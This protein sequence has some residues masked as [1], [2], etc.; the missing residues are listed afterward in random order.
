MISYLHRK[1]TLLYR[2]GVRVAVLALG[3]IVVT[4]SIS[5]ENDELRRDR[6]THPC[7]TATERCEGKIRVP[8]DRSDP[9]S[10]K[11]TV[12][13][14]W[15]PRA[16]TTRPATGTILANFGGPSA[17]I[18]SVPLFKQILGPVLERQNLLVVDPRGLGESDPLLCPGLDMNDHATVA[19]CAEEL[20]SRVQFYTTD[21]VVADMDAVREALGVPQVSFYGNSYGTVYAQ[22]YA[23]RFPEHTAALYLDSIVLIDDD[24]YVKE[25]IRT[26]LHHIELVCSRSPVCDALPGSPASILEKLV[27]KLR[28]VP[29]PKVPVWTLRPL[30]QGVN[31]VGAREI[32]A[33]ANAYLE[34]DTAPLHRLTG[35][36]DQ[37]GNNPPGD[38]EW[39][40][41]LAILCGDSRFPYDRDDP[42]E[43]R[44]RQ[45]DDF[46]VQERPLAPL[47]VADF[48]NTIGITT[49]AEDCLAWPT[50]HESPPV[51]AG[52][53]YPDLPVL[54]A[55]G[56]FDT[57]SPDEVAEFIDRFPRSTMLHV[58]YG[59]HALAAGDRPHRWCVREFMRTFLKNPGHHPA[60]APDDPGGCD[61]E[62]FRAVGSFPMTVSEVPAAES[63]DLPEPDRRLIAA[64]FATAT[65]AVSRRNPNEFRSRPAVQDGLRGGEVRWDS[66]TNTITLDKVYFVENLAV[67]GTVHLDSDYYA[68][69]ELIT[70]EPDGSERELNI[71]WQEFVAENSTGITGRIDDLDFMASIPL[72]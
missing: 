58:R 35:D 16:D 57:H 68:T 65:D 12:A 40:G 54:V 71:Q 18:P 10:E 41:T 19:A 32:I 15:V 27:D 55:A 63:S 64:A 43:K 34:G 67:T 26:S 23:T 38:A 46:Y 28:T 66:E 52:A 4:D 39:A 60:P 8:L 50:P 1:T 51:P 6:I 2:L 53:T 62:N 20:G 30:M 13:F 44:R 70:I 25:P 61:A 14:V 37:E 56:D 11:I 29:D 3:C 5:A 47:E 24:G 7:A 42:D 22:A 72:H 48:P 45:L 21:Q 33:A 36:I 49:A 17:A 69:A 31:R 59:G 9:D